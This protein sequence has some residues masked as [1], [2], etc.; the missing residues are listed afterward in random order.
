MS[1][2]VLF[3]GKAKPQ[4]CV[5]HQCVSYMG[6]LELKQ[7]QYVRFK[8]I[9]YI[10]AHLNIQTNYTTSINVECTPCGQSFVGDLPI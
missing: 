3:K 1:L 2:A 10:L 6:T 8:H 9:S 5:H 4:K 7:P